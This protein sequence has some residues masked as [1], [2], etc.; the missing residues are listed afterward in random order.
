MGPSSPDCTKIRETLPEIALGIADGEQRALA[1]EHIAHCPD[2]RHELEQ[3]SSLADELITLAPRRE[4]PPGFENRVLDRLDVRQPRRRPA[5]RR[6]RR[7][8]FAAAM[9]AV[10][11]ATALLITISYSSDLRLA[12]QY[13]AALMG[14][15]GKYFQSAHLNTPAGQNA[16]VVFAYQGS[17]SWMFYTLGGS[18]G[19][20]LY[21]EQIVTRS[22]T[23]LTLPP[24]RLVDG[25]WGIATPVPVRDIAL[26]KLIRN[27]GGATLTATIP[28]VEQ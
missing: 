13:R 17:P 8:A 9:P 10:A 3:L 27:P 2:C 26:V 5:R 20:G 19:N 4:P 16:G 24:F 1:L 22:G 11:A 6:L 21:Q 15:H 18:Y 14:A 28:S 23:T 25:T 7:W 12:S